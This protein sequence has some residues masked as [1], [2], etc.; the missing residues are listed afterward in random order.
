MKYLYSLFVYL[1]LLSTCIAQKAEYHVSIGPNISF[2]TFS[3]EI[4]TYPTISPNSGYYSYKPLPA[5]IYRK[6][7]PKL[8]LQ[9]QGDIL[10]KLNHKF[11]IGTG[12]K[13]LL[14]RHAYDQDFKENSFDPFGRR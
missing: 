7:I 14:Y 3:D 11:Y 13:Y 9:V 6:T 5:N 1:S 12:L 10:H 4:H 2:S 8:G